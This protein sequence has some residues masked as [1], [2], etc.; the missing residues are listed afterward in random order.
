[1]D[2]E[3]DARDGHAHHGGERVE[4]QVGRDAQGA[5]HDPVVEVDDH[6]PVAGRE[7]EQP[8]R[9]DAAA[10]ANA[11]STAPDAT[12]PERP[13]VRRPKPKSRRGA[14]ERG[15]EDHGDVRHA[16]AHHLQLGEVVDVGAGAAPEDR[17]DD[18]EA[19]R[20]LG[21][22]DDH[23][24][25]DDDVP[26]HARAGTSANIRV[27]VANAM[28]TA[29]SIS[30]MHMNR[31][32]AFRR[33]STPNAPITKSS[34]RQDDVVRWDGLLA[35][36]GD[37]RD[38][39]DQDERGDQPAATRRGRATD[40]AVAATCSAACSTAGA[41]ALSVDTGG[42]VASVASVGHVGSQGIRRLAS[43]RMPI[44]A[45]SSSRPVISNGSR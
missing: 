2:Q 13:A 18:R 8:R 10:A 40:G 15:E 14:R 19:D 9:S 17:H 37:R 45:T 25:Q 44:V 26:V 7:R 20:H 38:E 24:E 1:M 4:A 39:K 41:G 33:S 31:T 23:H 29:F 12:T 6:G 5:D 35:T 16:C 11:R 21:R 27:N 36:H 22:R 28:L 34:H 3:P 42:G 32:I 30:S 43:M